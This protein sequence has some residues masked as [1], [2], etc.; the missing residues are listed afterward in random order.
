[1]SLTKLALTVLLA[2]SSFGA[3][4]IPT[5]ENGLIAHEWGTF[6]SV[7]GADG[8]AIPWP[9]LAG[10]ADLPCF[11]IRPG[12][13]YKR[14]AYSRVRMETPVVYF[15]NPRPITVSLKVDFRN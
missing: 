4:T 6:T 5:S 12:V 8:N 7:A 1:M 10:P 14:G 11:V 15:Y 13:F 3:E 9:A 2:G